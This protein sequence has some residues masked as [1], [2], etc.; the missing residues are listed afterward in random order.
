MHPVVKPCAVVEGRG[1]RR[2]SGVVVKNRKGI[3][4]RWWMKLEV[5]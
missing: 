2:G 3:G 5:L 4:E 1:E